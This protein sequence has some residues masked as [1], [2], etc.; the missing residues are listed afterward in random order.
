MSGLFI[1]ASGIINAVRRNDITANNVANLRTTGFRAARAH[2][3]EQ[4]HG[5][6]QI[7]SVSHDNTPG[8]FEA[9]GSPLDLAAQTGFFRV[10]QPDGSIAFTRDGHFGLNANGEVVTA[11]GARLVPPIAAPPN[12][13]SVTVTTDGAVFASVPPSLAPQQI[14]QIE[15]VQ[16]A[17]PDG[18]EGI[19]GNLFRQT[20]ASGLP[21]PVTQPAP[22]QPGALSGSNVDL[23]TEQVNMILDRH[24]LQAN[25]NAFRVQ[26]DVLGELLNITR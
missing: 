13:S 26:D 20:S 9:T 14:G 19:G 2:S 4:Q 6:V 15:V 16:F 12:A 10:E 18:L 8:A 11:N 3:V 22:I 21:V 17:N 1:S 24:A 25:V 5:G 7:G 23:A